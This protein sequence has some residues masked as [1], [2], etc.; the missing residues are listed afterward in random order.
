MLYD[1]NV[2]TQVSKVDNLPWSRDGM[3]EERNETQIITITFPLCVFKQV[4][5]NHFLRNVGSF[6]KQENL[7]LITSREAGISAL[8][9]RDQLSKVSNEWNIPQYLQKEY[10]TANSLDFTAWHTSQSDLQK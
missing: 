9:S 6:I 2:F 5:E 4:K 1:H 3:E 8:S 7:Q 10:S